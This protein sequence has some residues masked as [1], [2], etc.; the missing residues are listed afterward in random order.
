[1]K[2]QQTQVL[3]IIFHYILLIVLVSACTDSTEGTKVT[4]KNSTIDPQ[5]ATSLINS[6]WAMSRKP[7]Q[8]SLKQAQLLNQ[9]IQAL[10]EQT[11]VETLQDARQKWLEAY[12]SY[13]K[14][15][16]YLYMANQQD[17]A[18]LLAAWPL[19]PGYLDS[20]DIYPHSGIVHDISL[21]LE[22]ET[23]REQHG[24]T[25]SEDVALG[26][27]AIEFMLWAD[28]LEANVKRLAPVDIAPEGWMVEELPN[29]RRRQL[30]SLQAQLLVEE[31]KK[32]HDLWPSI[33]ESNSRHIEPKDQLAFI[34]AKVGECL[35]AMQDLL[36]VYGG[37]VLADNLSMNLFAGQREGALIEQ[38]EIIESLY[39]TRNNSLQLAQTQLNYEEVLLLSGLLSDLKKYL[40]DQGE[41]SHQQAVLVLNEVLAI[42]QIKV[43]D[44]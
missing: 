25:S 42:L 22:A 23:V 36:S 21:P 5:A 31:L 26:L 34:N 20:Y 12:R 43:G 44:T 32:L 33:I 15:L 27:H 2:Y 28:T 16:P 1:M 38:L 14:L 11:S 3:R 17:K 35:Q 10:L 13:R 9:S 40:A 30:V 18:F 37:K 4:E 24:L 19:Q 7:I 39:L 41:S 8:A 6:L 29:N